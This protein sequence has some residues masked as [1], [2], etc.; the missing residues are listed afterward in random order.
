MAHVYPDER[1]VNNSIR[2]AAETVRVM[3]HDSSIVPK[4]RSLSGSIGFDST[5]G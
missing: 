1:S 4:G 2:V 5:S 3:G